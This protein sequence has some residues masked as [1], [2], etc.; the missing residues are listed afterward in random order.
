MQDLSRKPVGWGSLLGHLTQRRLLIVLFDTLVVTAA[1]PT[2]ILLR[3][4]PDLRPQTLDALWMGTGVLLIV[5]VL[6]YSALALHRG[7]WRYATLTEL[8][9]AAQFV[10]LITVIFVP[11]MFLLDRLSNVPRSVIVIMWLLATVGICGSRAI[12]AQLARSRPSSQARVYRSARMAPILLVGSGDAAELLIQ[13]CERSVSSGSCPRV[14]GILDDKATIGRTLGGVP[15]LGTLADLRSSMT[16]LQVTGLEPTR[17]IVTKAHHEFD[18]DRLERVMREAVTAGLEVDQLPDLLRFRGESADASLPVAGPFPDLPVDV[19]AYHR[20]RRVVDALL[21]GLAL[22]VLS[23]LLL[24]L[25]LAVRLTLGRPV[26][27][28]QVRLGIDGRPFLLHKFRTMRDAAALDG[29]RLPD[30]ERASRFG[31]LLRRS[32]LDEL[33]Q[34]F[35]VLKGEMALVGP[36]PLLEVEQPEVAQQLSGYRLCV[37]PGLTGWAQVNGGQQLDAEQKL[38]LDIYYIRNA[39]SLMDTRIAVLTLRMML[40]GEK[41][42]HKEIVRAKELRAAG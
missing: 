30:W 38:A 2:A 14:V 8:V 34:L 19:A 1:Y 22:I 33:P 17:L 11:T 24:L 15:I 13:M 4:W 36:R 26:F 37:R 29:G 40:F 21:S 32:R 18:Q 35:N 12:Y 27:F 20:G 42:N 3:E 7:M 31:A 25:A 28:T 9:A 23:P 41:V 5:T 6:V 16:R 10:A 39:S